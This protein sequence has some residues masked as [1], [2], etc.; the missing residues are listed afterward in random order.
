[1][2]EFGLTELRLYTTAFIGWL[3]IV[4]AWFLA[5][6][7]RGRRQR[8]AFG[9]LVAGFAAV[10]LLNGLNPDAYIV[11][12]NVSRASPSAPLDAP[13]IASLSADAVPALIG[14]LPRMPEDERRLVSERLLR[15][16]SLPEGADWRTWNWGRSQASQTVE[17]HRAALQEAV[18]P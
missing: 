17:A 4:F 6:V 16:Q 1:M 14:L 7:L 11:R 10:A 12:T 9:A 5:T 8:F 15:E 18:V 13:Y 2:N 3:A